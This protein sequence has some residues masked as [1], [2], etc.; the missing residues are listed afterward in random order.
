MRPLR[1]V[2]PALLLASLVA[3]CLKS[4]AEVPSTPA[5]NRRITLYAKGE[6]VGVFVFYRTSA[7]QPRRVSVSSNSFSQTGNATRFEG[8]VSIALTYGTDK[9]SVVKLTAD[10]VVMEIVPDVPMPEA[11]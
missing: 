7:N 8:D 3:P 1:F 10:E 5:G 2:L 4:N 6:I 11:F 9:K